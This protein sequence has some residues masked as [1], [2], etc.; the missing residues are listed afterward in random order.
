VSGVDDGDGGCQ[1]HGARGYHCR[2]RNQVDYGRSRWVIDVPGDFVSCRSSSTLPPSSIVPEGS[3]STFLFLPATFDENRES[4]SQRG[5]P[6][7]E[8]MMMRSAS[9][10]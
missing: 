2:I 6:T 8:R 5:T 7:N 1:D 9:E 4:P 10:Y 3:G